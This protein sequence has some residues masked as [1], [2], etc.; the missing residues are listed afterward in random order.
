MSNE[1]CVSC[2][3][4]RRFMYIHVDYACCYQSWLTHDLLQLERRKKAICLRF[5]NDREKL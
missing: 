4:K 1:T 5:S 3:R 2:S